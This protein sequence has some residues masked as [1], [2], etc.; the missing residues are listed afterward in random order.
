MTNVGDQ[1]VGS[2]SLSQL[3]PVGTTFNAAGSPGWTCVPDGTAGSTCT[4]T[5]GPLA[6]GGGTT[7]VDFVVDVVSPVPAGLEDIDT[8]VTVTAPGDTNPANDTDIETTPL[9]ASPDVA[10]TVDDG[11][12]TATAGNP[13]TYTVSVTNVGDQD[14]GSFS[15]SQLVPVGTTFNAA[16]SPGWT[17]LP[18]APQ[19]RRAH[20]PVARLA[21]GGGT[22][23]VDFVVDVVSPVAAGLEDI[24]TSVTVTAPGDTNAANDTDIETTPLDASPDVAVTIDDGGVTATAGNPIAYTVSVTN[25]GD[26][27]VG[28]FSLSQL[29]PVGTTFDAG[30][31]DPGWTCVPDGTAGSTC[32]LT[33]GALAGGGGTTDVDFVVDVVSPVA[34]GLEDIDTSVTVTAPGDTNAANDTDI[35]TTPLDASPDV[36]VTID[37]AGVTATAGNPIT[38]TVSVTNV[39]DQDVGSFSLSQLVPVGTT[40][41]AAGSPGWTCLPDGTAGSTCT[42]TG[43]PLA[44]GGGT[45][46]VDFVVDVVSPVPAGLEDIDTSVTVTAAG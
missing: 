32:T 38:Y 25:V 12:V 41:N 22:T 29:V 15:L 4:F 26:Q 39:G 27:G 5:G 20:S 19:G 2:F 21:G 11:G 35:E 18:M 1:G 31:S 34:A 13:I 46:D 40:F 43:G 44:G 9:D 36:A 42:F 37:D 30:G 6:G 28:S 10:V 33:G 3:V 16:G 24:D 7:D 8:A 17:C 23:D 14:V 45:T